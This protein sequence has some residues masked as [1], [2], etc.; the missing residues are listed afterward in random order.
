MKSILRNNKLLQILKMKQIYAIHLLVFLLFLSGNIV[1]QQRGELKLGFD[2]DNSVDFRIKAL[3]IKSGE[4]SDEDKGKLTITGKYSFNEKKEGIIQIRF[5][6]NFNDK[7]NDLLINFDRGGMAI[8]VMEKYENAG[9]KR[10]SRDTEFSKKWK[11]FDKFYESPD[12]ILTEGFETGVNKFGDKSKVY[13]FR[14]NDASSN[15]KEIFEITFKSYYANK[16]KIYSRVEPFILKLTLPDLDCSK[17]ATEWSQLKMNHTAISRLQKDIE[18]VI[19]K[20]QIEEIKKNEQLVSRLKMELKDIKQLKQRIQDDPLFTACPYYKVLYD[21]IVDYITENSDSKYDEL[22]QALTAKKKDMESAEQAARIPTPVEKPK[23]VTNNTEVPKPVAPDK[24]KDDK[25]IEKK[26]ETPE[27]TCAQFEAR[28]KKEIEEYNALINKGDFE[29]RFIQLVE[30]CEELQQKCSK[31]VKNDKEKAQ[32]EKGRKA[33]SEKN[34]T[35][36]RELKE[37][38]KKSDRLLYLFRLRSDCK[39]ESLKTTVTAQVDENQKYRDQYNA[40]KNILIELAGCINAENTGL[41]TNIENLFALKYFALFQKYASLNTQL[42]ELKTNFKTSYSSGKYYQEV[43][44][45]LLALLKKH[46]A[47]NETYQYKHDSINNASGKMWLEQLNSSSAL[48]SDTLSER[49]EK[50]DELKNNVKNQFDELDKEINRSI[51]DSF[52]IAKY[53]LYGL[54]L[55]IILFGAYVYYNALTK[56][57]K[58]VNIHE[59]VRRQ[60]PVRKPDENGEQDA[61][62][63]DQELKPEVTK[64]AG[65]TITKTVP[66]I[67]GK[68]VTEVG[69][70]FD[71]VYNKIGIDYYEINLQDYWDDTLVSKVYLHRSCIKKTYKFFYESCVASGR[72]LET[73]GFIIGAWE[74]DRQDTNKYVVSLED[75]IEPGDDAIY[76]EYQLNFGAKIGIRKEKVIQD[77]REKMGQD[78]TLTAWFHSHPEIKIFLSNHDLDVQE[79]LSTLEHKYKL[80]ALVIDPITQENGKNTFLTGIFTYKSNGSMNNN[81]GSMKLV[82][83]RELYDWALSPV[84]PNIKDFYCIEMNRVFRDSIVSKVC[85]SDKSITRFSIFLDELQGNPNAVGYFKG[86]V[87]NSEFENNHVVMLSDFTTQ[88]KGDENDIVCCFHHSKNPDNLINEKYSG[89]VMGVIPEVLI[90]TESFE[91]NISIFTQKEK[92]KFNMA[93][94]IMKKIPFSEIETWPTRRR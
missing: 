57:K 43:K 41:I 33:V 74:I 26:Q 60:T 84:T 70:G 17:Y 77:Y 18:Q 78:F 67:K 39:L 24:K 32:I 38:K 27:E 52:P 89:K 53:V 48:W 36:D 86:D 56:R 29:N 3:M 79:R 82:R 9:Q 5:I 35:I 44:N 42:T 14:L 37:I 88:L 63:G 19:N 92:G 45:N 1:G 21:E 6:T 64:K 4:E 65:I 23:E 80:L 87:I 59:P 8:E 69:R 34:N 12:L 30:E 2:K 71:H 40:I 11:Q 50:I 91:K 72:V 51:T 73:G 54:G 76:G 58:K 49:I 55:V 13:K 83:W 7:S 90:F 31:G 68:Q 93:K 46:S 62:N 20:N 75:F 94:D 28:V 22:L 81:S 25:K 66:V 16:E 85:F 15:N 47:E 10:L 61:A